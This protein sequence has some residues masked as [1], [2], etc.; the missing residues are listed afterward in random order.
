[1]FTMFAAFQLK[2]YNFSKAV[3]FVQFFMKFGVLGILCSIFIAYSIANH[4]NVN[5]SMLIISSGKM[6]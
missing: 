6:L 3:I 2:L 4:L 5:F 1:M